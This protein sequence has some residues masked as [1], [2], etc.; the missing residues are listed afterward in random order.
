MDNAADSLIL[1]RGG[2]RTTS[3]LPTASSQILFAEHRRP[4][5]TRMDRNYRYKYERI[6]KLLEAHAFSFADRAHWS[7][8]IGPNRYAVLLVGVFAA[9]AYQDSRPLPPVPDGW[10]RRIKQRCVM[11]EDLSP[12]S[13]LVEAL[14]DRYQYLVSTYD[15]GHLIRL[16]QELPGLRKTYI[17]PHHINTDI[18]KD[19]K[20]PKIHDVLFYGNDDVRTYPF[21]TRLR[22]LLAGSRLKVH[23]IKHPDYETFDPARCGAALAGAINQSWIAIA[24]PSIHDYLVAK[25]FEISAAGAMVAG[26]MATQG[27]PIWKENYL[28]L[29]EDMSDAEILHRL[30]TALENKSSL[31]RQAAEMNALVHRE[32]SLNRYV[33]R[34]MSAMHSIASDL[35]RTHSSTTQ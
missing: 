26:K 6:R 32:Y 12:R 29:E 35:S 15:C 20:M 22:N 28:R 2:A 31:Q 33:E 14:K 19:K 16:Q 18:Y 25:Y 10:I 9:L 23:V 24:T 21:R 30:F 27:L 13:A 7:G 17:I 1:P 4:F 11:V 34:L 8:D 3:S 5:W